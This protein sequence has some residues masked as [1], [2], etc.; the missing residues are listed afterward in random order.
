ME[1][2]MSVLPRSPLGPPDILQTPAKK[3]RRP[4]KHK[5]RDAFRGIKLGI[6][7]HSSFSV[8]FLLAAILITSAARL[9]ADR[10]ISYN[11]PRAGRSSTYPTFGADRHEASAQLAGSQPRPAGARPR[12]ARRRPQHQHRRRTRQGDRTDRGPRL[13]T[14]AG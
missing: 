6:R 2:R 13:R 12:Q 5:F 7:G 10:G 1:V 4:W 14:D 11:T 8:P 9:P 3:L